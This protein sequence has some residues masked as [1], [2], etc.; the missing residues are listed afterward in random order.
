MMSQKPVLIY[1]HP[2]TGIVDYANEGQWACIV[3]KR[4]VELLSEA[5]FKNYN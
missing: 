4:S 5:I 3:D 1:A 2:D